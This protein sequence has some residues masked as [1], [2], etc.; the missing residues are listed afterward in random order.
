VPPGFER[1]ICQLICNIKMLF[2]HLFKAL[3]SFSHTIGEIAREK[4]AIWKWLKNL[5]RFGWVDK[6]TIQ[7]DRVKLV[8]VGFW[9]R[10]P[11]FFISM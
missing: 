1:K 5:E 8:V 11:S 2:F 6:A 9:E 3:Q 10:R 7:R 4:L